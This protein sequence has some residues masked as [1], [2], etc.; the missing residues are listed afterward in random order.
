M[1]K[2][3]LALLILPLLLVAVSIGFVLLVDPNDYREELEGLGS[4]V[5]GRKLEIRGSIEFVPGLVPV[6]SMADV[7][8]G[9]P[10]WAQNPY[11]AKLERIE[12]R[13]ELW[14]ALQGNL[15]LARLTASG[16]EIFLEDRPDGTDNYTFGER[17]EDSGGTH[18]GDRVP[19][20]RLK[21]ITVSRRTASEL[22]WRMEVDSA[23]FDKSSDDSQ[24]ITAVGMFA[25][26]PISLKGTRR[27]QAG[28][29]WQLVARIQDDAELGAT[30]HIEDLYGPGGLA[31]TVRGP[32]VG[33]ASAR[34]GL[35]LP[36]REAFELKG[37][38]RL[39]GDTYAVSAIEGTIGRSDIR[40]ELSV[41]VEESRTRVSAT[42]ASDTL[43]FNRD[44]IGQSSGTTIIPEFA[45]PLEALRA[46]DVD[47]EYR[48]AK[49]AADA[50]SLT[51]FR[52]TQSLN[53]G[54]LNISEISATDSN[55]A[56]LRGQ[57]ELDAS[58][59]TPTMTVKVDANSFDLGLMLKTLGWFDGVQ[60]EIDIDLKLKAS[61]HDR[62]SILSDLSGRL[63]MVSG[64][65]SID[66]KNFDLW[67]ADL[68]TTMLSPKWRGE[69]VTQLLCG[70]VS[71]NVAQGIATVEHLL[72]DTER[73]AIA[74]SGSISLVDETFDLT[75]APRPK[76]ASLVSL[77]RPVHIDGPWSSPTVASTKVPSMKR[78]VKVGT[79]AVLNPVF[80]VASF[81][82]AGQLDRNECI[83]TVKAVQAEED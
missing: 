11:L 66:S 76:K 69:D 57:F 29:S 41:K 81:S 34:F 13:I 78:M 16:G 46:V 52:L 39:H 82:H 1:R 56:E 63:V 68:V 55:G 83:E 62:S 37:K 6:L 65:G 43:A 54:R 49:V 33:A 47:L 15:G 60:E 2:I 27:M 70:V 71:T 22:S 51:D 7:T 74:G 45:V 58:G 35:P 80:L 20:L 26:V 12:G 24:Q 38:L 3:L 59:A 21:N 50:G 9:N 10:D 32:D 73:I 72:V 79:L 18:V 25:G 44:W 36:V 77:A 5:L 17:G 67:A 40:G 28:S 30:G 19:G 42:L 23:V 14:Q 61:G 53:A 8:V 75:L 4:D 64:G 48:A 31:V